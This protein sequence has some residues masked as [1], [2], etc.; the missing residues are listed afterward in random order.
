MAP[1]QPHLLCSLTPY[2]FSGWAACNFVWTAYYSMD[3]LAD[4]RKWR[5]LHEMLE[6]DLKYCKSIKAFIVSGRLVPAND[7]LAT[8]YSLPDK[9]VDTVGITRRKREKEEQAKMKEIKASEEDLALKEMI[10][11]T[12]KEAREQARARTL[13][14][15]EKICEISC[16][17]AVLASASS[18]SRERE[19]F[20]RLVNLEIELYNG[21]VEKEGTDGEKDALKAYKVA[22]DESDSTSVE[23]EGDE[24][25]SALID[26]VDAMLQNLETEIDYICAYW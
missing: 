10:I 13:E 16:A 23:A 22:H 8:L 5:H 4:I 9:V 15:E 11:P 12:A 21:M 1:L 2:N 17:L 19:A 25:S 20:L 14:K 24:V 26:K 7:V 18:V 3:P 6:Q